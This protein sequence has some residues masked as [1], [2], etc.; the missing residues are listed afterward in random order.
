MPSSRPGRRWPAGSFSIERRS[1]RTRGRLPGGRPANGRAAGSWL[2]QRR[3]GMVRV[4]VHMLTALHL[5]NFR[6]H[7]DTRVKLSSITVLVG[8]NASGKSSALAALYHLGR[9]LREPPE[10]PFARERDP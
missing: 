2:D 5:S 4:G 3:R 10:A 1:V 8:P 6:A 9:P 7:A